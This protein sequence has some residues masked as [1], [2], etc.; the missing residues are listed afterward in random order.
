MSNFAFLSAEFPT[1]H[2]AAVE[3]GRQPTF[4]RLPYGNIHGTI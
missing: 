4:P 1:V 2:K 3:A